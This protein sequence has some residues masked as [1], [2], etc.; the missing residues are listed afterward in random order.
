MNQLRTLTKKYRKL[1]KEKSKPAAERKTRDEGK[2]T[3]LRS[4]VNSHDVFGVKHSITVRGNLWK[5]YLEENLEGRV[6]IAIG[7]G[8]LLAI[9]GT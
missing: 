5:D 7:L 4:R 3:T 8:I 6:G 2:M 1:Q 9:A